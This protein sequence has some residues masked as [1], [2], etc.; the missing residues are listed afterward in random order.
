M[1]SCLELFLCRRQDNR[2]E[3]GSIFIL[4]IWS[5]FFLSMLALAVNA[6]IRPQVDLAGRLKRRSVAYYLAK[7]GAERAIL[8]VK[9]D[10]T[11]IYDALKDTWSNNEEMFK[12]INLGDGSFSVFNHPVGWPDYNVRYGLV[13]EERKININKAPHEVLK[14]LF[15]IT[16]GVT[17]QQ[18][19]DIASSIID[20]RDADEIPRENGAESGYY[21]IL[22]PPY[23]CKNREFEILQ[24]LLLVKGID[25]QIFGKIRDRITVYGGKAVNINTADE[26]VLRSLGMSEDLADSIVNFRDGNDGIMATADDN[27]FTSVETIVKMFRAAK[28]LSDGDFARLNGIVA[29]GFICVRSENFT[30]MATGRPKNSDTTAEITFVFN[31]DDSIKYWREEWQ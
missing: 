29:D 12:Q 26:L 9:N 10:A 1:Q 17:S 14:R 25:H 2:S 11:P 8:E 31:R 21:S 18:A 16:A 19:D 28:K 5:L 22:I 23:A 30:G 4:A 3:G 24:E 27:V 7:A 6:Y 15:E 20:W 13:D